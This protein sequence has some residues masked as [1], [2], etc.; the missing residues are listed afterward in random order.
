MNKT[1]A[2]ILAAAA[3][4]AGA[5]AQAGMGSLAPPDAHHFEVMNM[6]LIKS[7]EGGSMWS[8]RVCAYETTV[9]AKRVGDPCWQVTLSDT[10]MQPLTK[11][12]L[13][14]KLSP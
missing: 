2:A 8:A 7:N 10:L 13:D 14:Q 11:S 1:T 9:Q 12:V 3:F 6:H 4:A 5:G